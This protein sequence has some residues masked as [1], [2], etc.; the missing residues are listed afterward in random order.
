MNEYFVK[1]E[2]YH[3]GC[4]LETKCFILDAENGKEAVH[5]IK[6]HIQNK[7]NSYLIKPSGIPDDFKL[8]DIRRL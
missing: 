2:L 3:E 7:Q 8:L 4:S 1:V 6:E 5:L